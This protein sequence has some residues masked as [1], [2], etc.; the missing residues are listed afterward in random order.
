MNI[1]EVWG[2]Y[3]VGMGLIDIPEG[4]D[5]IDVRKQ[6]NQMLS[7]ARKSAKPT[8]CILC[9]NTQTSFCNSHSVPQLALRPIAD[10][11]MVLH[12]SVAMGLDEEIVNIE[13][14]VNK[15]GTFNYICRNCDGTFFQEYENE[16]NLIK[17]PTDK[18]LAEIAV[19]D[20]L[21]LMSKRATEKELFKL[22]QKK[23]SCFNSVE[24]II[25]L[26]KLDA[27]E[28][29]EEVFFHKGIADYNEVGGYQV[30]FWKVLPYVIPIA[31]QS[32]I[33]LPFDMDGKRVN[34]VYDCNLNNRMQY[35]HLCFFPLK[36]QSVVLVFYHKRDKL[37]RSLRHQ[38]NSSSEEKIL[39]YLNYLLFAHTENYFISKGVKHEIENSDTLQKLGRESNGL[40]S[41]GYLNRDNDFGIGYTPVNMYEIPNFLDGKWAVVGKDDCSKK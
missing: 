5:V 29:K 22:L 21:L 8:K 2:G 7:K 36:C 25:G 16:D 12:A 10:N 39:R 11:G 24:D 34:D 17:N 31:A 18:M 35:I 13:N 15:S 30:L 41:L 38:I 33:A 4:T 20:M 37:Y 14:G 28:F 27:D 3:D 40:P 19:K 26:K 1:V 32:A 6:M 23:F 9:G